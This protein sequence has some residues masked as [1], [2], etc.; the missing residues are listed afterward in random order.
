MATRKYNIN[1]TR[2][3]VP[4]SSGFSRARSLWLQENIT[5]IKHGVQ[6]QG[7]AVSREPGRYGYK[8]I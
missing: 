6:C 7:P 2:G 5:L 8:K 3:P 4:G 1:K